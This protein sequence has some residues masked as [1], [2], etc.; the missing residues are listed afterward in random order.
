MNPDFFVA[1]DFYKSNIAQLKADK[2]RKDSHKFSTQTLR[3]LNHA[4]LENK[5]LRELWVPNET[6][7]IQKI[8]VGKQL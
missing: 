2:K 6:G 3:W 4:L 8:D 7:V 5:H 1:I